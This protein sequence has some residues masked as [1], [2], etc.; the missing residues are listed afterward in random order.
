MLPNY[1]PIKTLIKQIIQKPVGQFPKL[2][3]A[4]PDTVL[5]P[6][7]LIQ[8]GESLFRLKKYDRAFK[9]LRP[10]TANTPET[11]KSLMFKKMLEIYLNTG[12]WE[13]G[14][15]NFQGNPME[16]S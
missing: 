6:M 9:H 13:K 16:V 14:G 5:R 2:F 10:F 7:V 4:Y 12:N 3:F 8:R 1:W 15:L 11:K